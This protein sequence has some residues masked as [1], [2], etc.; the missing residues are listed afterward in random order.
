MVSAL[1]EEAEE[2]G[3]EVV[4]PASVL[5]QAWRGGA[6]AARLARLAGASEVDALDER[7]AK[8]V[9]GRLG[10]REGSDVVDA[11]VVCCAVEREAA[12]LTSDLDD[13]EALIEPG[14]QV[15]LIRV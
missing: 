10:S 7:R 8:Q 3:D 9:G 14:E 11:H 13:A 1:L 2:C 12:I 5:A 6:R 4:I 15:E